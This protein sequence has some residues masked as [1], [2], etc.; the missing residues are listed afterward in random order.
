MSNAPERDPVTR[1]FVSRRKSLVRI[2]RAVLGNWECARAAEGVVQDAWIKAVEVGSP[3]TA[4]REDLLPWVAGVVRN[5]A[6]NRGRRQ[7]IRQTA[8]LEDASSTLAE[9][10]CERAVLAGME[11]Q[12]LVETLTPAEREAFLRRERDGASLEEIARDRDC[13]V[14][15]VKTLLKRARRKLRNSS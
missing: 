12:W 5:V 9:R 2:A 10:S 6:R 8:P 4:S 15:T 13:T 1:V 14:G 3:P 11:C 7:R